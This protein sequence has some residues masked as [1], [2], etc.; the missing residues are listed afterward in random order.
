MLVTQTGNYD[1]L[2]FMRPRSA[3]LMHYNSGV[4]IGINRAA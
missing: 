4:L 3:T 2:K 1:H